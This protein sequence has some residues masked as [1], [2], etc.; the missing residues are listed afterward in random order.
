MKFL[1]RNIRGIGGDGKVGVAGELVYKN[2]ISF[3]GLVETKS[4]SIKE[5]LVRRIWG[6]YDFDWEVIDAINGGGGMLCVWDSDFLKK[7]K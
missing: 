2:N 6:S 1:S 4:S 7:N 3:L 5:N